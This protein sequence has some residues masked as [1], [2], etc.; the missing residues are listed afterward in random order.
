MFELDLTGTGPLTW[1]SPGKTI[2]VVVYSFGYLHGGVPDRHPA[3]QTQPPRP[4]IHSLHDLRKALYDPHIQ[5]G[6]RQLTGL[7]PQVHDHVMATA[8][9]AAILAGTAHAV[10]GMLPGHDAQGEL[11]RVAYGCAGGRHRSVVLA[12]ELAWTLDRA[13]IGVE[14]VHRDVRKP[15][16]Q[17]PTALPC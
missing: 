12:N 16:V 4:F 17:R 8:G 5:P 15:V 6:F 10:I 3:Q 2:Q 14:L 13:G 11:L 1:A 9:A 7:D